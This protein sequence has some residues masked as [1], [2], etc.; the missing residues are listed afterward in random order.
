MFKR[1]PPEQQ[2]AIGQ[3]AISENNISHIALHHQVS[4]NTVYAQ[5]RRAQSA[6]N[7]EFLA[8]TPDENVLFHIPVTKVFLHQMVIALLMICKAS[9]RDCILFMRDVFDID[10]SIGTIFNIH[11]VACQKAM[12]INE[13]YHLESIRQ[14]ASDE[15]FHRNKPILAVV[16]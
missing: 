5:Q 3:K 2:K 9:Y 16:E 15:I 12:Q 14:S 10:M 8:S 11:E 6:L 1:L 4:R 7:D 13:S